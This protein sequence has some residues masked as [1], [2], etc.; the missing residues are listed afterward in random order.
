V[1]FTGG[2]GAHALSAR[3]GMSTGSPRKKRLGELIQRELV[4]LLQREVKDAR[5]GKITIT[6][7]DVSPDL[8]NAKVYY[9]VFG[10]EGGDPRVQAGLESASP[11]LRSA[12]MRELQIR[13]TPS[14]KFVL[15]ES[16]ERGVKLTQLIDSVRKTHD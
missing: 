11:F 14:L 15:D 9:L 2:G 3:C 8:R 10:H 13:Y 12:L 7:V 5:I 1:L 6:E 4:K 16:L